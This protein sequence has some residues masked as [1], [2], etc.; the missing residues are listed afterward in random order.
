MQDKLQ[1]HSQVV[2]RGASINRTAGGGGG[3]GCP[4]RARY[5]KSPV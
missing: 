4:F 5:E 1:A 3:G 2:W